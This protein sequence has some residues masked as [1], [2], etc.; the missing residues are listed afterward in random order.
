M[1]SDPRANL[2][3]CV[4]HFAGKDWRRRAAYQVRG[5]LASHA[6]PGP[7]RKGWGR[8]WRVGSIRPTRSH[9]MKHFW[10]HRSGKPP[11]HQDLSKEVN[12]EPEFYVFMRHTATVLI[13]FFRQVLMRGRA[14]VPFNNGILKLSAV[15]C[16]CQT[17]KVR[18]PIIQ[19]N[20][21]G[22][23]MRNIDLTLW[24]NRRCGGGF[25]LLCLQKCFI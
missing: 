11:P 14:W 10:R 24:G 8:M 5:L 1:C 15:T 19:I 7:S 3:I 20:F 6:A 18:D 13:N 2:G 25:P 23:Q 9:Q 21:Y 17:V 22:S 12:N 4:R 16:D